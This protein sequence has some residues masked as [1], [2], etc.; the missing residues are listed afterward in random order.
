M[1]PL[2]T[3]NYGVP[4]PR[5]GSTVVQECCGIRPQQT[6][7]ASCSKIPH[8][9]KEMVTKLMKRKSYSSVQP[10][11]TALASAHKKIVVA[12]DH[13]W[14]DIVFHESQTCFLMVYCEYLHR[15]VHILR[16]YLCQITE[17]YYAARG[18]YSSEYFAYLHSLLCLFP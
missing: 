8:V 9:F 6:V 17:C 13:K 3:S 14:L 15:S 4:W 7:A 16:N 12:F 11:Q 2:A 10:Q 5:R 1:W 18:H